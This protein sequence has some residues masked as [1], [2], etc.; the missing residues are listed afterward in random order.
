MVSR[1]SG[2]RKNSTRCELALERSRRTRAAARAAP[3][4]DFQRHGER[5]RAAGDELE[6]LV[7]D[8][9]H[10]LRQVERREGGI[11][12][13]RDDAVGER[14][15]GV[16]QAVALAPEQHADRLAGGDARRHQRGRPPRV[17]ITGFAWSC[18]RAVVASTKVQSAIA[19][20]TVVEQPRLVE[21]AV[22]AGGRH[23]GARVGPA[24]ARLDQAQ[25]R[26]AEI[27][28]G[29]RGGADVVAQ[30]R[31]DQDDDRAR[32]ALPRS[33]SCRFRRP[34]SLTPIVRVRG[35]AS[36]AK[37]SPPPKSGS[38]CLSPLAGR[39]YRAAAG[40]GNQASVERTPAP[41][42]RLRSRSHAPKGRF[43]WRRSRWPIRSS[44]WTATR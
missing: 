3:A 26:Q 16:L 43:Q 35:P 18:A 5:Q 38:C 6:P 29:A 41:R 32:P 28:H 42:P 14:D 20:S 7:G 2:G 31:L 44:N 34:A 37:S 40:R 19:C 22:G 10:R 12:R 24:V 36:A 21:D 23:P 17:P 33:W 8:H 13:Q 11:D 1:F 30:L 9:Q 25:P 39:C 4:S 27:R 15:L